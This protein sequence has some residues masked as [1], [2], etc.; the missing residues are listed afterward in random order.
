MFIKLIVKKKWIGLAISRLFFTCMG[1]DHLVILGDAGRR[2]GRREHG[3]EEGC[4]VGEEN[5]KG[6]GNPAEENAAGS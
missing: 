3:S 6:E 4:T 5:E 1:D 2:E